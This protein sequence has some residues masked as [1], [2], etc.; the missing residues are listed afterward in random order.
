M[1]QGSIL[2][3]VAVERGRQER[4]FGVQNWPDGTGPAVHDPITGLTHGTMATAYR[5][6]CDQRTTLGHLT[7]RDI[8]QE[9]VHEALAETDKRR[10]RAELVQVAAVA[11]AWVEKI[12]RETGR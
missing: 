10:L 7:Y 9:E 1:S 8:L 12:D 4:R 2:A 5:R 11:V 3:E 6:R